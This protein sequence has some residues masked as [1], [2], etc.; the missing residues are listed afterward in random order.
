MGGW[1]DGWVGGWLYSFLGMEIEIK[2]SPSLAEV[3]VG[4][5]L[6]SK[7]EVWLNYFSISLPHVYKSSFPNSRTQNIQTKAVAK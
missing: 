2:P 7:E 3:G 1:L 4:A 5:E 6:G